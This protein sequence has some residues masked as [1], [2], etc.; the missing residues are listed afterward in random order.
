MECRLAHSTEGWS[1]QIKIRWE[2]EGNKRLEEVEEEDFG[3]L[4]T[5][6]GDVEP[7]LR[8]A[9]A[10]VL[11]PDVDPSRFLPS[12]LFSWASLFASTKASCIIGSGS[13]GFS[14]M[15][16]CFLRISFHSVS[17]LGLSTGTCTGISGIWF[18]LKRLRSMCRFWQSNLKIL[19]GRKDVL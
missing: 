16:P 3:P 18:I 6:K 15:T 1:C 19:F 11:N 14:G 5:D 12:S 13:G 7:M 2:Y 17:S 8:R 9:Q 10:A 4:L